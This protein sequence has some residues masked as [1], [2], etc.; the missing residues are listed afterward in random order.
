MHHSR[1][2][3]SRAGIECKLAQLRP[4]ALLSEWRESKIVPEKRLA[5]EQNRPDRE[6]EG[7]KPVGT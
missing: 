5:S 7:A 4:N 3:V 1:R 6:L 2:S